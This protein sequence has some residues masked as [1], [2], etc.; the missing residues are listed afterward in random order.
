[1]LSPLAISTK[2]HGLVS[3]V[4]S[5]N[6]DNPTVKDGAAGA[7]EEARRRF[8]PPMKPDASTPEE[9]YSAKD[10]AVEQA[11]QSMGRQ[12]DALAQELEVRH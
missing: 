8:L 11:L 6:N 5:G 10:I 1:M 9:V 4:L 3:V 12:I 7:V 2:S